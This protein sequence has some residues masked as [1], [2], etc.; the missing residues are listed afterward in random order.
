[1]ASAP[2]GTAARA[3]RTAERAATS[4]HAATDAIGLRRRPIGQRTVN[5]AARRLAEY[6]EVLRD[7][8]DCVSTV[9]G[10]WESPEPP[11]R[12]SAQ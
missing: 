11:R 4:W 5:T 10:E 3:T 1:M 2:S 9:T 7:F 6:D 12:L 8:M